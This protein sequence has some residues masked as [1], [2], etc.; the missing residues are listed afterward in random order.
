MRKSSQWSQQCDLKTVLM[1]I[2]FGSLLPKTRDNWSVWVILVNGLVGI[3]FE[4]LV[5]FSW[6][7]SAVGCQHVEFYSSC[8]VVQLSVSNL[9][10]VF[11]SH[12]LFKE[13]KNC[14]WAS[15]FWNT[16]T[17]SYQKQWI[18][19][20]VYLA[21]HFQLPEETPRFSFLHKHPVLDPGERC[22][23]MENKKTGWPPVVTCWKIIGF[24]WEFNMLQKFH[25]MGPFNNDCLL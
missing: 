22:S 25:I 11:D 2:P 18:R 3:E 7:G 9:S 12:S 16:H 6:I 13:G 5:V 21:L 20:T 1:L 8:W 14:N 23:E 4:Y 10:S 24:L 15:L 19:T 17:I